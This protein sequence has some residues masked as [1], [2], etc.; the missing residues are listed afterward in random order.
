MIMAKIT[1]VTKVA[2]YLEKEIDNGIYKQRFNEIDGCNYGS[3]VYNLLLEIGCDGWF[4]IL[5]E[6]DVRTYRHN[7]VLDMSSRFS[8]FIIDVVGELVEREIKSR[9]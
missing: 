3:K 7:E 9:K 6:C 5:D 4:G 1:N 2:N 8:R